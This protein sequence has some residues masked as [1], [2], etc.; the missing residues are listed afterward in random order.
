MY[1]A[2]YLDTIMQQEKELQ[3]DSFDLDDAFKLGNMLVDFSRKAPKALAVRI[4]LDDLIAFQVL[5]PGTSARNVWW[6]DKKRATVEKTH[7]SSLRAAVEK[8]VLG[9]SE[10]WMNDEEHY[11]LCGGGFPLTVN[12]SYR[13]AV[14]VSGLPHLE[15]HACL[16]QTIRRFKMGDQD[17]IMGPI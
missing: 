11:A 4:V 7:T 9:R 2:A 14:I 15:D 5:I 13:G 12:G 6:M 10:D 3:F 8:E 1:D 16:V 17:G